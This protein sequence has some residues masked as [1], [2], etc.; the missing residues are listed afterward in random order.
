MASCV[1]CVNIFFCC[2]ERG[3]VP[4]LDGIVLSLDL[5][6]KYANITNNLEIGETLEK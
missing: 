4:S 6:T 2:S 1:E 3:I 5:S